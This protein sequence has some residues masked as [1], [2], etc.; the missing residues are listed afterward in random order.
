[1]R[2]SLRSIV[3]I[4]VGFLIIGALAL[5]FNVMGA[6]QRRG[7]APDWYFVVSLLLVLPYAWIGGRLR[8]REVGRGPT[9]AVGARA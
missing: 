2:S 1:M 3:A 5:A 7:T 6:L 8:E 9:D 4:V